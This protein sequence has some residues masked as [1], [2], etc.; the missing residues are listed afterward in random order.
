MRNKYFVIILTVVIAV[1]CAYYLSFT[2]ISRGV[3]E[4]AEAFATDAKGNISLEKKQAYLDSVWKRP[5]WNFLGAEYTYQDVRKSELGLGLDLKGG[6]NVTLEVSPVEI[7][8]VMSGNSKDSKFLEALKRAQEL[9]KNSQSSFVSLFGQAYREVEPNGNLSRIFANTANK[10]KISYNSS[11]DQVLAAI[12][13][14][15]EGAIDRSFNILRTRIDKFGVSEPKIQRQKGTGRIQIE[16]PG[17]DNPN[18]VRKL[19]QG[20][21]KLEFWEVWKPEEFSPFFTQMG[22]YLAA[23]EATGGL[24]DLKA[25]GKEDAL[26]KAAAT[27]TTDALAE[28]AKTDTTDALAEAAAKDTNALASK[29]ETKDTAK[30]T[31]AAKKDSLNSKQSSLMSQLF[32]QLPG[33]IGSNVRDT[34]RVNALF[35]KNEIRSIFPS[36]LQFLWGVKPIVAQDGQ[37]F[38]EL[39]AI[40]KGRDGKAPLGGEYISEARQDFDQQGRPEINMQMNPAG[41]K[42]WQRLTGENIGR[43]VAIVLDDYV[44]SAPV[45]QSEIA[46]A[47]SSISGNF[48]IEEAQDLANILKAGKMPAPT[49]IV[50]EAIV[51]PSLGQEAINQGMYSTLAALGVVMLFMIIYYNKAGLIADIALL[52]N[53]FFT[54]GILAQFNAALSLPGIAGMV[55]TMGMAVDANVLIFERIREEL[56]G[57]LSMKDAIKKGYNKAFSSIFDSHATTIL[58]GIILFYWGSGLVKGFAITLMLGIATSFLTAVFNSRLIIEWLTSKDG[59]NMKFSTGLSRNAFKNFHFDLVKNRKKAYIFSLAITVIGFAAMV[60]EGG[61]NLGVD[62]KGGRSYVVNFDNAIPA[63]EVKTDLEP[64][65]QH[66]GTEVKTYGSSNRLKITT[67]YLIDDE[68]TKGD[69]E[70]QAALMNGLK[71]YSNLHPTILSSSKVGATM[72]DDIQKTALV[73]VLLAFGGIFIYIMF[74]FRS[75]AYALGSIVALVHDALVV[76]AAFA[77]ANLFGMD[78]E[79]DQVFIAALLTIIGFSITDTVVIY[80]RIREYTDENPKARFVDLVNPA[81]N[82]TFSRTIITS[83]TLL[84]VVVVLFFFGGETLRGFSFAMI[85][86]VL[87]GTYSSLFIATPVVLETNPD[88]NRDKE[89]EKPIVP[90]PVAAQKTR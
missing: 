58:A 79:I 63:S 13:K 56:E 89:N 39:Y 76:I 8:K 53:V 49:R 70:V 64:S 69:N 85:V 65:F 3:Q 35:R 88:K 47:N 45:V 75:W 6:M 62:F 24:K 19:L 51:G 36:N 21:A 37:E 60:F 20:Q 12:D 77:I 66:K 5:V 84:L 71:K 18:R 42:K 15:V 29:L 82:S 31:A 59:S 34:A 41:G 43:Q 52:V 32:T 54:L 16:L 1:L 7:I 28:A 67:S 26:S 78:F 23:Q 46:G 83:L 61:P 38:L 25:K 33:G 10:G 30:A 48:T 73:A 40:K 4:K 11:N 87:I 81:L 80:D 17:V 22:E 68:S 90:T 9:Q 72:A 57:G 2:F 44:Y 74:R 50:E 86:G 55:L 27:D 14:E